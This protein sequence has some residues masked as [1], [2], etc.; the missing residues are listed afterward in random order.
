M[1][2]HAL[3]GFPWLLA[4]SPRA[5]LKNRKKIH[6]PPPPPPRIKKRIWNIPKDTNP[7][8][9]CKNCVL[10]LQ[11]KEEDDNGG[12]VVVFKE[13]KVEGGQGEDEYAAIM[14]SYMAS[15]CVHFA[16]SPHSYSSN[17]NFSCSSVPSAAIVMFSDRGSSYNP[18][19]FQVLDPHFL[20]Y[21]V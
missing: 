6:L 11:R 20:L 5:H 2:A 19:V 16:L 21:F 8:Y 7:T 4:I 9:L 17:F 13:K 18:L 10:K 14:Q 15:H 12:G 3:Q 1:V